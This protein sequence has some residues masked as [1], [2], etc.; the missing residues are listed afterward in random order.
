[1]LF[2]LYFVFTQTR[3]QFP[4]LPPLPS[5]IPIP[6]LPKVIHLPPVTPEPAFTPTKTAPV[7]PASRDQLI[8]S[9][10]IPELPFFVPHP[11]LPK[12]IHLP[13]VTPTPAFTPAPTAPVKPASRDQL[14]ESPETQPLPFFVPHPNL[15]KIIHLTHTPQLPSVISNPPIKVQKTLD[16]SYLPPIDVRNDDVDSEWEAWKVKRIRKFDCE[17]SLTIFD[18]SESTTSI[19]QV[20]K[21]NNTVIRSSTDTL[22]TSNHITRSL[23]LAPFLITW[24]QT[25]FLI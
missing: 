4:D 11:N 8:E 9:P 1:M 2:I 21:K 15:P 18:S 19:T 25:C 13:S 23:T 20:L 12:I 16:N 17:S 22:L 5:F 10:E 14:I 6:N 3:N 24:T 7:K